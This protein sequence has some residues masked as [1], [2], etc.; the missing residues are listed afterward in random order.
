[1]LNP[2][3]IWDA[4]LAAWKLRASL[5]LA[6]ILAGSCQSV[7]AQGPTGSEPASSTLFRG[8]RI[9]DGR[10]AALS[11]SSDVLITGNIIE[12]ISASPITIDTP[13]N[14]R[15]VAGDG[16]VLMPGLIDA[17]WHAMLAS[18]TPVQAF[19]DVGYN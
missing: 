1:M 19:G 15:V 9:F 12:R 16:R 13:A 6:A 2:T 18:V 4:G 3:E 5:L 11:V 10:S 17:H 8:V 7:F 14:V